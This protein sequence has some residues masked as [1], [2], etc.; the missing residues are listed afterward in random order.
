MIKLIE[1]QLIGKRSD[2]TLC[3]D[4]IFIGDDFVA[5]IDGVTSKGKQ[6]W[7]GKFTSGGYAKEIIIS[8]LESMPREIDCEGFF[9]RLDAAMHTAYEKDIINDDITEWLRACIIVYSD[10]RK[11][12]WQ[13]G[14]CALMINGTLFD[15]S[16]K[17]DTL[18]SELRSFTIQ[19]YL[20]DG[21]DE[22]AL[23][24]E[25]VGRKAI[26]PF[27]NCQLSFENKYDSDFGY[28]VLNGHGFDTCAVVR[29]PVLEGDM[30]VLA[31]DGYPVLCQTL[32][33]SEKALVNAVTD[34]P[35]CY[36]TN[37]GTKGIQQGYSS[38]DDRS[39]I[40]FKVG[41]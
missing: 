7:N 18:L 28:A 32:E 38:F 6:V 31:S 21:G 23:Y 19:K 39:Y 13:V 11:E 25:D 29:H 20:A 8:E 16:K 26:T 36:K 27:I 37:R 12:I 9:S 15:N 35:L 2:Q 4:G 17:I 10:Y 3:E 5:V 30:I 1:K 34:D 24:T 33:E 41:E 22:N 40:K 14:D